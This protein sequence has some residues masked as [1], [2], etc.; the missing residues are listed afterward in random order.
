VYAVSEK[1]FKEYL[2]RSV[3]KAVSYRIVVVIADFVAR[4]GI[5]IPRGR[6][7][8]ISCAAFFF[9]GRAD[10]A[11]GFVVVSNI[12]TTGLYLFH[13]RLWDRISR[14]RETV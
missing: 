5:S 9:T 1:V 12:Y 10:I 2:T 8:D 14:G 13:E 3:V 6:R 4:R 7:K 11:L